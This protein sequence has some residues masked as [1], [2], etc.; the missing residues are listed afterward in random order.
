M[1]RIAYVTIHVA[2]E[3]MR[4]GVGEKIQTQM[5]LWGEQNHETVLF[6]LT[7]AEINL[8]NVR[9]FIF[10]NQSNLLKRE[11]SRYTLLKKMLGAIQ[12]YQPDLIYLRYG[13]YS[14]PLHHIFKIAPVIVETNSNDIEEY[15]ARGQFFYWLN[16]FTRNLTLAPACGYIVPTYELI[17]LLR[18]NPKKPVQV[19]SNGIDTKKTKKL[20][21]PNNKRPIITL[22]GSPGMNWHGVDKLIQLAKLYPDLE[23]N[24][25][26]YSEKDIHS[27]IPANASVHGFL[28]KEAIHQILSKTDVAC[29]TLALHRKNMQEACPLKVREA[30]AYGIPLLI[31]YQDTDLENLNIETI[32]R[33]PNTEENIIQFSER[34]RA[35]AYQMMG[36][37]VPAEAISHLDQRKKE[38]IRLSFFQTVLEHC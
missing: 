24:I 29:G 25:I 35:F 7:P 16:R 12:E 20:P 6:S 27:K 15:R 33:I 32:L 31:A 3:I 1:M 4:G 13:L 10:D 22:I 18:L 36:K 37:R 23:I 21:A 14:Y 19:I 9:Q 28:N 8:P 34:I 38:E 2:P 30:L 26:G 17:R 11:M 5:N